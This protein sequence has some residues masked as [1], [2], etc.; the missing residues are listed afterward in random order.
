[1][2]SLDGF[3]RYFYSKKIVGGSA[4]SRHGTDE[5]RVEFGGGDLEERRAT[6]AESIGKRQFRALRAH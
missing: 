4:V 6:F 3:V 5:V 1:M 2:P